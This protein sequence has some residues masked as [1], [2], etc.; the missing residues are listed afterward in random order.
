MV[1]KYRQQNIDKLKE[2]AFTLYKQGLTLREVGKAICKSHE[3]V[4]KAVKEMTSIYKDL[5]ID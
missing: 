4:R 3:W 2:K 5:K 1:S